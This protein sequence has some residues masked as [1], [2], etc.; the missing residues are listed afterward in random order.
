MN[1]ATEI[2]I[3]KKSISKYMFLHLSFF[4]LQI[5][6]DYQIREPTIKIMRR[7]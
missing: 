6:L 1:V 5:S 4:I 2:Y 3:V 7:N